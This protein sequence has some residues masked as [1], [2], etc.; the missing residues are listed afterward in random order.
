MFGAH[1]AYMSARDRFTL[2]LKC[3]KC[4]RTGVAA[5]AEDD[6]PH[7]RDPGFRIDDLPP[8][9]RVGN[10]TFYRHETEVFCTACNVRVKL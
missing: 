4:G 10:E 9:F 1:I 7:M 6:H 2:S 8:G 5:V 3:P